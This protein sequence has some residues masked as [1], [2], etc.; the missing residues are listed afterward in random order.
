MKNFKGCYERFLSGY[1]KNL[2]KMHGIFSDDMNVLQ[3]LSPVRASLERPSRGVGERVY[4]SLLFLG[5]LSIALGCA[6][7]RVASGA[8]VQASGIV[9]LVV[10]L[11][12][13]AVCIAANTTSVALFPRAAI[14]GLTGHDWLSAA[15][16][17]NSAAWVGGAW[18]LALPRAGVIQKAQGV[19]QNVFIAGQ[20]NLLSSRLVFTLEGDVFSFAGQRVGRLAKQPSSV[21]DVKDKTFAL[22]GQDVY[23]I[24][25]GITRVTQLASADYSLVADKDSFA[26]VKGK[27]VRQDNL[28][29][30]LE[31]QTMVIRRF[32]GQSIKTIAFSDM[33][34]QIAVGGDTLAVASGSSVQ[35]FDARTFV[36]LLTRACEVTR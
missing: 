11:E 29:Y 3:A 22:V 25:D 13:D 10:N 28:T 16:R 15:A 2:R 33:P 18:W 24:A 4:R 12:G 19:P 21:I 14:R 32:D 17:V 20:P 6:P 1:Q 30:S 35:F 9:S 36:P 5:L 27:A 31:K 7:A 8:A 26:T 23:A 34:S